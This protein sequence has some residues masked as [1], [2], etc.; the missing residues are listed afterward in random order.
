MTNAPTTKTRLALLLATSLNLGYSP[1]A[2]GTVGSLG[3]L[4]LLAGLRW[5]GRTP[6]EV[7]AIL[8]LLALG[9]W[10]SRVA[11]RHFGLEDPGPVVIDEVVGMLVSLVWLPTTWQTIL[12]GFLLFRLFDIIKPYPAN[13]LERL[14]G[15]VG[16]MADDV[17]AGIYANLAV[18][19]MVS[20]R[21]G[22]FV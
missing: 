5:I 16:I 15:G 7:A 20:L 13:R 12:A 19:G 10:S 22:W 6:L 17:M 11:E 2:P 3:G 9:I 18:Q 1:F 14:H 4:V 8:V 21:P